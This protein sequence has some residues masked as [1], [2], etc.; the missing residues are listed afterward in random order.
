MK[1]Y[2]LSCRYSGKQGDNSVNGWYSTT[3]Q[4]N[5][6]NLPAIINVLGKQLKEESNVDADSI[7]I[8]YI[9][10]ITKEEY[11]DNQVKNNIQ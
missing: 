3:L 5:F 7:C 6:F 1:Y 8:I 10:R 2:F 4:S 11:D 9:N